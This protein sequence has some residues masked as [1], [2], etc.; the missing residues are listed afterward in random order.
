MQPSRKSLRSW[1]GFRH[2]ALA[3][4][5]A[6][7]LGL[8]MQAHAQ[9]PPVQMDGS[10]AYV[11]G[12]FGLEE[13]TAIKEAMNQYPLALTFTS[14][15]EGTAAYAGDVQVVIRNKDDATVLN[16]TSKGPYLLVRLAPG[17]Y[18]VFAT[19]NNQTQSRKI[20][21]GETGTERVTFG[22]NRPKSGPD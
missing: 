22:W 18:Q 15:D 9:L 21:I 8:A 1:A 5:I 13:S 6:T 14:R 17:P 19:Y 16:V 3:A 4:T 12:G 7:S 10:T 11:T 20:T 2:T